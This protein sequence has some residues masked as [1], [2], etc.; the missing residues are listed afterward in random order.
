MAI[1]NSV[2]N[3]AM[4]SSTISCDAPAWFGSAKTTHAASNTL[5]TAPVRALSRRMSVRGFDE[6]C[7]RP[8]S[9]SLFDLASQDGSHQ[10][11]GAGI[12]TAF[13]YTDQKG[14]RVV[15]CVNDTAVSNKGS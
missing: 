5:M 11:G 12:K 3:S 8:S 9:L 2:A 10:P 1:A 13:K 4:N 6:W 15:R 14:D 7:C